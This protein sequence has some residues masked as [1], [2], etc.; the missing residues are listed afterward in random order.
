[1]P[2]LSYPITGVVYSPSGKVSGATVTLTLGTESTSATSNSKGEYS[3]NAGNLSNFAVGS[4]ATLSATLPGRGTISQSVT[5]TDSP[6]IVDLVL[7][8]SSDMEYVV[9]SSQDRYP[10]TFVSLLDYAGNKLSVSNPLH[11]FT[12]NRPLT[13]KT[14]GTNT[15]YIG[16]AA[17]GTPVEVARWRIR[18]A[19]LSTQEVTWADG[20]AEFDKIWDNRTGYDYS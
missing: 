20:N 13:Q 10:L 3:V 7:T 11:V 2:T 8:E 6:Q 17:P 18:K 16:E 5:L 1:M 9:S 14:S 12:E 19:I 4:E 15:K